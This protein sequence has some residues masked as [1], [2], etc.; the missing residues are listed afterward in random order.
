DGIGVEFNIIHDTIVVVAPISG[1]P[2]EQLG[3]QSGDKIVNIDGENVAG[4]HI[5][6]MGV[7]KRLRGPKGTKVKVQ[8]S[9]GKSSKLL[10]YTITR[11]KIPSISVDVG[12]MLDDSTGYLKVSRFTATTDHELHENL[13]KLIKAGMR[14]LVLDL[15]DNSGGYLNVAVKIADEFLTANKNIVYTKSKNHRY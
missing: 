5:T 13:D 2:S 4:V 6:N 1:G 7:F 8:I 12:Y 10:D 3:I 14:R 11:E 9:R 15:R